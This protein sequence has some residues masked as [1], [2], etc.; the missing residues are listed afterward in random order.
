VSTL[1]AASALWWV[2]LPLMALTLI[3]LA[4]G[5]LTWTVAGFGLLAVYSYSAGAGWWAKGLVWLAFL[6][7]YALLGLPQLRRPLISARVLEHFRDVLLPM[8]AAERTVVT[9][10]STWWDS[11]IFSGRPRW[12]RLFALA[13]CKLS[14]AERAFIEGSVD[15][16]CGQLD[17]HAINHQ[18]R[19]LPESVW[20]TLRSE[21]YFGLAIP[22]EYGGRGFS[23][24]G[25]SAVLVKIATRSASAALVVAAA[26]AYAPAQ[27]L[28]A[29]GTAAQ[30][31]RY[32]PRLARGE[33]IPCLAYSGPDTGSDITALTD[34]GT[35]VRASDGTLTVRL[36]FDKRYV[37]LGPRASLI[38]L[39]FKLL[40]PECLLGD[41]PRPGMSLALVDAGLPGIERGARHALY[42]L[43]LSIGPV[44][45]RG[46]EIPVD[47]LVGGAAGAGGGWQMLVASADEGRALLIPAL[48]AGAAKR[49][50][51]VAGAHA[52]IRYQ[53]N[54]YIGQ[55][56]GVQELLARIAGHGFG[57]DALRQLALA[58]LQSGDRPSTLAASCKRGCT[59]RCGKVVHDAMELLGG[60]GLCLGPHNLLAE[61]QKLAAIG[62]TLEGSNVLLRN[63][64]IF[65]LG[66][67]RCHP[68]VRAEIEAVA[69]RDSPRA[70]PAFDRLCSK[71]LGFM[72][73]NAL[74]AVA[75]ALTRGW[76]VPLPLRA[77]PMARYYQQISRYSAAFALA[78]DVLL[79][80][81]RGELRRRERLSARM[82]DILG[83]LH[84]A[85]AALYCAQ[86]MHDEGTR[87]PARWAL[88]QSIARIA[89]GFDELCANLPQ[90][91]LGAALRRTIFPFRRLP[92]PP[93][94]ALDARL[95]RVLLVPSSARDRLSTG[96]YLPTDPRE[97]LSRLE[98][99]LELV[100]RATPALRKLR[101][102]AKV[103]LIEGDTVSEQLESALAAGVLDA[104]EGELLREAEAARR[105]ALAVDDDAS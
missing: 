14:D 30:R 22:E 73:S 43:G 16:L 27:L 10:S 58:G 1:L 17:D 89:A 93:A 60:A 8:S 95:A 20:E 32:L 63:V 11:E 97:P 76:L 100:I 92:R 18:H 55:F 72:F 88:E 33:E 57:I 42:G 39:V 49:A 21:G 90:R 24:A 85:S 66:V 71:H 70:A 68:Y 105:V 99:A 41:D 13:P 4:A 69:E 26:N 91:L 23:P 48:C 102:A 83:E 87:V 94:D 52:R 50:C 46:V 80:S 9:A 35:V 44:R 25:V 79:L 81:V 3:Y 12:R 64:V 82:A 103:R 45:G 2:L 75:L 34:T 19:D 15:T 98:H 51:R 84:V 61:Y 59:T 47:A 40:D 28:I 101:D 7:P 29:H 36:D 38:V 53:F 104:G 37:T 62:T 5:Q 78:T 67:V 65:G 6:I 56:E 96:M 74:R 86:A 54:T 77:R 31:A